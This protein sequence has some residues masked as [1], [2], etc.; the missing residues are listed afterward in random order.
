MKNIQFLAQFIKQLPNNLPE[1]TVLEITRSERTGEGRVDVEAKLTT[2]NKAFPVSIEVQNTG[3]TA[4]LREA[5]RQVKE[6]GSQSGT[7]P[8]VAGQFFGERARQVAK[9]EGVGL[10]DLA[11]NFYLKS[12]DLYIERIVEKNPKTKRSSLKNLFAPV[13]SRI[14]RA[15]LVEPQRIWLLNEISKEADVSL[16]QT[17]KVIERMIEEE[18]V[19]RNKEEKLVLNTPSVLLEEWKKI[20]PNYQ[21]QKYTFYSYNNEYL[22]VRNS[23]LAAGQQKKLNYAL[24]FFCGADMI[25]SST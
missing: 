16:G 6:Y 19:K 13:S 2:G 15:L 22:A 8:F 3:G 7:V 11:G 21:Q 17:Y 25:V 24:G 20:Y 18:L 1:G 4:T 9:E 5:A 23:V 10:I 12:S 14:T